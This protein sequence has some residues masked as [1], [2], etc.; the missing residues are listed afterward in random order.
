[1]DLV[2]IGHVTKTNYLQG[3]GEAC[4]VLSEDGSTFLLRLGNRPDVIM[5][6]NDFGFLNICRNHP[7][8]CV[9]TTKMSSRSLRVAHLIQKYSHSRIHFEVTCGA[10]AVSLLFDQPW[11]EWIM[12]SKWTSTVVHMAINLSVSMTGCVDLWASEAD[13]LAS[14]RALSTLA[15]Q[16]LKTKQKRQNQTR[17]MTKDLNVQIS[18]GHM[19]LQK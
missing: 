18:T 1:M 9:S 7:N 13:D 17:P 14:K 8:L 16:R 5:G 15:T 2:Q 19:N 4:K 6:H 11:R 12:P 3:L 10:H